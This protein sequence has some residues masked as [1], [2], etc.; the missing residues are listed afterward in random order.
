MFRWMIS[1]TLRALWCH[2]TQR[3]AVRSRS[4]AQHHVGRTPVG[5]MAL[6]V[7]ADT[8]LHPM[9]GGL[10]GAHGGMRDTDALAGVVEEFCSGHVVDVP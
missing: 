7:E 2:S 6:V 8:R 10:L 3:R 4:S 9:D 1:K 5:G